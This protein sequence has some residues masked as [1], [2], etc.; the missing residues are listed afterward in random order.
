MNILSLPPQVGHILPSPNWTV[1]NMTIVML[2][3]AE[4]KH[5]DISSFPRRAHPV[6]P[7]W[8]QGAEKPLF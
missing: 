6:T 4:S 8:F 2:M 5:V 3:C 1:S 7:L